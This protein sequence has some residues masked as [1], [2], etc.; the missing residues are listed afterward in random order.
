MRDAALK[1]SYCKVY[2]P[3]DGYVTNLQITP[4]VYA[5]IGEQIFSIC[6]LYTSFL[7]E[8]AIK[9]VWVTLVPVILGGV[10][11]GSLSGLPGEMC[12]RDSPFLCLPDF[13]AYSDAQQ[14]VDTAFRDK[15]KWAEMAIL[16]TARMGKFSSDRTIHE[17]ATDIWRCV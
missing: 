13:R 5:S 8:D 16:N 1:L 10:G 7:T 3:C 12:I 4:G 2:A 17:Y 11:K 14:R 15:A 6:L 9:E